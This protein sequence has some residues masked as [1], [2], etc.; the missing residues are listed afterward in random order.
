MHGVKRTL[1]RAA[2]SARAAPHGDSRVLRRP[3]IR[4]RSAGCGRSNGRLRR[5][6]APGATGRSRS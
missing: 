6:S 3:P 4:T 5:S 1:W 2:E